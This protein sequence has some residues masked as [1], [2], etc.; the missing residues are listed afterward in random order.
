LPCDISGRIASCQYL[1]GAFQGSCLVER[2][3]DHGESANDDGLTWTRGRK[4]SEE[5]AASE[6]Q[7]M[8]HEPS[9]GLAPHVRDSDVLI[10]RES[11]PKIGGLHH[12]APCG[13]NGLIRGRH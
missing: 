10:G 6:H 13:W 9:S 5:I 4:M 12:K 1:E 3:T 11:A 2:D 7:P 8:P